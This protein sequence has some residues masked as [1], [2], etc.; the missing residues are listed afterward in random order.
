MNEQ[1]NFRWSLPT[2]L[3][4][5]KV[6]KLRRHSEVTSEP[7]LSELQKCELNAPLSSKL[8]DCNLER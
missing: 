5:S 8:Q 6:I 2:H 1:R 7:Q 4:K 3:S